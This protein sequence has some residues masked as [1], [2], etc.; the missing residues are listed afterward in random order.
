MSDDERTSRPNMRKVIRPDLAKYL[1]AQLK[2][3]AHLSMK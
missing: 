1:V 2:P 3:M